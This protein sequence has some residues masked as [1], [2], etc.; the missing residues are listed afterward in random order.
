MVRIQDH[1]AKISW[2][3][4][5]KILFLLYGFVNILQNNA[6]SPQELGLYTLCNALQIFIFSVSDGF[7]LQ[8]IIVVGTDKEARGSINRFAVTWHIV[9]VLGA[10]LLVFLLQAPFAWLL[11]E[12]RLTT[13]AAYLPLFC[14][15]GIP[16][17]LSLK[18]LMRDVQAREIFMVNAV[19]IGTMIGMTAW[20]LATGGLV[21]FEAMFAIAA[22]GMGAS[23]VVA[24]WITRKQFSFRGTKHIP[25]REFFHGGIYQG[26]ASLLGNMVRQLDVTVVQFFFGTATVGVYQ[27]AKTLFRFFDE[28]F[29]AIT[30][31][32]YPATMRLV[33]EERFTELLAMLSK[34]LSFS[35]LATLFMLLLT[36]FGAAEFVISR[37]LSAKY[38]NA[39]GY[40]RLLV[41]AAPAM[42]FIAL[43]PVMLALGEVRRLLV[44]IVLAV[45]SGWTVLALVGIFSQPTFAPL[46][47]VVYTITLALLIFMFVRSRLHFPL[48]LLLRAVP[49]TLDFLGLLK[50]KNS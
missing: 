33:H 37:L 23:S 26:M 21:S 49:D 38:A 44:F 17:T 40:F 35:L 10:S 28:G 15:L 46:G 31:L 1:I 39:V 48:R 2:T 13:V 30:S 9:L 43:L 29:A 36:E 11:N 19:W 16:R 20:M 8:S 41:L 6:L 25:L 22:S 24:F 18:Y 14:V 42:P 7:I 45:L 3:V 4:A 27:S 47:F 34:M 5:D 32:V 50:R 12:P